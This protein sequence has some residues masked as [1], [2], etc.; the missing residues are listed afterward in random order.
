MSIS[1]DIGA[2]DLARRCHNH[3]IVMGSDYVQVIHVTDKG[4]VAWAA[5]AGK[6][7]TSAPR[8]RHKLLRNRLVECHARNRRHFGRLLKGFRT[9]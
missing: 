9:E 2:H 1:L 5:S 3:P 4:F 7:G 6:L 8:Q